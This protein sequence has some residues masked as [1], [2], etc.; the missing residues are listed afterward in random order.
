MNL[1]DFFNNLSDNSSRNYKI[2]TLEA[3]RENET[4]REVIRLALDPFTQFYIRKIPAY[5]PNNSGHGAS[6]RSMLPALYELRERTKT[7]NAA[8]EHQIGRASCRE[9]VSSP[10]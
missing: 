2:Q 1:N 6:I 9:R 5:T 10:V 3:N 8:I 7:G 4:L